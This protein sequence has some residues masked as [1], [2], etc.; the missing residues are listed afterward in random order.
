MM[1]SDNPP[2]CGVYG[3]KYIIFG[4]QQTPFDL[5]SRP[6]WRTI[7]VGGKTGGVLLGAVARVDYEPD[8]A[9]ECHNLANMRVQLQ[10]LLDGV[11]PAAAAGKPAAPP[12]PSPTA[13]ASPGTSPKP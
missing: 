8:P 12:G 3:K 9:R 11:Q 1:L 6:G 7:L 13:G 4:A 10:N 5:I 2:E